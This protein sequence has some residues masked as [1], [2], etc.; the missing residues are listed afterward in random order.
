MRAVQRPC[1]VTFFTDTG[2]PRVIRFEGRVYHLSEKLDHF[3]AGGHW[4]LG[5]P[6][7]DV[8]VLACGP[9]TLE[10]AR[11]DVEWNGSQWWLLRIQD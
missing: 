10:V 3:R 5:E 8:W 4:W 1:E 2:T 7:R 9:V 6:G 11:Y